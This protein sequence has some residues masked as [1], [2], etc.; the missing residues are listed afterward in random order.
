MLFGKTAITFAYELGSGRFLYENSS[1]K[2]LH[3]MATATGS[4]AEFRFT[5]FGLKDR[6]FRI[7]SLDVGSINLFLQ[8]MCDRYGPY[9]YVMHVCNLFMTYTSWLMQY[10][11]SQI[12]S[13]YIADPR[14]HRGTLSW[15][16]FVSSA[17]SISL[18]CLGGLDLQQLGAHR[19]SSMK[20]KPTNHHTK[21]FWK[22]SSAL[23]KRGRE[24]IRQ[25]KNL[26]LRLQLVCTKT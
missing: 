13:Q 14:G 15:A 22:W 18:S 8:I 3:M 12:Y 25:L 11:M 7:P 5:N 16:L 24:W 2:F 4:F 9:V 6:V 23:A 10:G 1:T 21:Q 20:P 26:N 19:M 17:L